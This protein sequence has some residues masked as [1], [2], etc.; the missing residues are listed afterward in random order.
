MART[1]EQCLDPCF[2]INFET[3][4]RGHHVYKSVWTPLIGQVL[5]AKPDERR[6]ALDYDKYSNGQRKTPLLSLL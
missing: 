3:V 4:F 2:E 1:I 6:E 5:I